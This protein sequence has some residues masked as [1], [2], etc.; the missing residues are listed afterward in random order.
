MAEVLPLRTEP[1]TRRRGSIRGCYSTRSALGL[2]APV[3]I[4]RRKSKSVGFDV[5]GA[6]EAQLDRYSTQQQ[7][8]GLLTRWLEGAKRA[9]LGIRHPYYVKALER[10]LVVMSK[11]Q[12]PQQAIGILQAR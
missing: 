12:S 1:H 2:P 6:L 10:A 8:S 3:F 7:Q 9:E 5:A 4:D 11:T